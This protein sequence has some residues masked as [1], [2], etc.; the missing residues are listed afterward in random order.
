MAQV[1]VISYYWDFTVG[2]VFVRSWETKEHERSLCIYLDLTLF[3]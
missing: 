2:S 3:T 1:V